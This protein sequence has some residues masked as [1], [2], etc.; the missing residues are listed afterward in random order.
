MQIKPYKI[1]QKFI[2]EKFKNI[3]LNMKKKK[4]NELKQKVK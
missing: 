2:K 1:R 3:N 4:L